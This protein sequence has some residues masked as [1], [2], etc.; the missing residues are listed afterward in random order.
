M[1]IKLR[2]QC[3]TS[4]NAPDAAAGK[5]VKCPGCGK[6]IRVPSSTKKQVAASAKPA[7]AKPGPPTSKTQSSDDLS[8][9]FDEAGLS[10]RV[11]AVCPSC[12]AEMPATAVL[13]TKCGYHKESGAKFEAHKTAGVDIDHGTLALQ[14][15]SADLVKDREMQQKMLS[16][17]GMPGWMLAL[18]L[19]IGGGAITLVV[20]SLK[21][22]GEEGE[23]SMPP[24]TVSIML[25]AGATLLIAA[26]GCHIRIA[27]HAFRQSLP[28]GFLA[29]LVPLFSFYHAFRNF[30]DVGKVAI[31]FVI[32]AAA[33][34]WLVYDGY[35]RY[36]GGGTE[37][38]QALKGAALMMQ[39]NQ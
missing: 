26:I 17:G 34:G 15:A 21:G 7:P 13:C 25:L 22:T 11:E 35:D 36:A 12:R 2:C 16:G 24:L 32:F 23:S 30:P 8:D 3:G 6:A 5:A 1:P 29:L 18:V 37:G 27:A 4:L 33:G 19:V 20:L 9:L 14:K 10:N 38:K 39:E 31:G 28:Q